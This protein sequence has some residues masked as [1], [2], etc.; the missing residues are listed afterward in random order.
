MHRSAARDVNVQAWP[1]IDR[2]FLV[3]RVVGKDIIVVRVGLVV[4]TPGVV[5]SVW[6]APRVTHLHLVEP[7]AVSVVLQ[8]SHGRVVAI[9]VVGTEVRAI[10]T[11]EIGTNL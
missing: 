6:V 9:A 8:A 7:R 3:R 2:A 11:A 5:G 1:L 10:S 4:V